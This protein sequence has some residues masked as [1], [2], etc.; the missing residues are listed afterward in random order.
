MSVEHSDHEDFVATLESFKE[1]KSG[2]SGSRI[3]KLTD[4]AIEHVKDVEN[5]LTYVI[6][7]SRGCPS[8]H[9]LGSLYI[10]DSI[11][12]AFLNKAETA[13]LELNEE[14][15]HYSKGV[16]LLNGNIQALL[17]DGI[18][19]SDESQRE[20]IMEL[21]NIWDKNGVF[22]KTPLNAARS[23]LIELVNTH[24]NAA[25]SSSSSVRD[26]KDSRS[27]ANQILQDIPRYENLPVVK[28]PADL[29]SDDLRLQEQ[30]LKKLLCTL[31]RQF[32]AQQKQERSGSVQSSKM[33]S[34]TNRST[35]TQY[36]GRESRND[37]SR[38][39][40]RN[41]HERV[42]AQANSASSIHVAR[43]PSNVN[44]NASQ[45]N[46]HHL[47]PD[48][49]NVPSNP[50]FRPKPVSFDPSLPRDHVKVFSRTLFVGGVPQNFKEHDIARML[51]QFGEVQSVILNNARK[52][53]FVKVYS[54]AEAE[55]IMSHFNGSGNGGGNGGN[56]SGGGGATHGLRIRWA[57]GFGPRDCCD[58][59]Y[60]FSIIPL[61]RL[62]EID[63]KWSQSA[64]WGGTGGQSIVGNMV[65]EEPDIIV[66]EGVSSKAISQ[67]M[68]TDKGVLGPKSG[69]VGAA[70]AA[71]AAG[72]PSVTYQNIS[73]PP[74]PPTQALPQ[75]QPQPQPQYFNH[76]MYP[77]SQ[78]M[79]GQGQMIQQMPAQ[80]PHPSQQKSQHHPGSFD[81]TA[82]LNT[83]MSMLNQQQK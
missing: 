2:I 77:P 13:K 40:P 48:E 78:V 46:N 22:E 5:L 18:E 83:L 51:R 72:P 79:Y 52:H 21:I 41:K 65:Y 50:H 71:A 55:R 54:R 16:K 15:N 24:S 14:E 63:H 1:L 69:R 3:R 61:A 74:P 25:S 59:Q 11:V 57:V 47:Y 60:G 31:Q 67:K 23:K 7:Y 9:K 66:G 81:P 76:Q 38:S 64:E 17:V 80:Q 45:G 44:A 32:S 42:R 28:V 4:Y 36:I 8:T 35:R 34:S 49:K 73:P 53:A 10:I 27:K 62:T 58:Y 68:P 30:A 39:P 37:R 75:P 19:K 43:Q 33:I 82:Q 20:K 26:G 12:R 6:E 29:L 56:G 70:A